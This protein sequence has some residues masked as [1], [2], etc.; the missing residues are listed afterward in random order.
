VRDVVLTHGHID[1]I[2]IAERA[3]KELGATV[4]VHPEDRPLLEHPLKIAESERSPVRYLRHGATRALFAQG[5]VKGAPLGKRV[6]EVRTF[7]DGET[8]AGV[9]GSPRVVFCPGHTRGH[10]AFHLAD[11]DVL[12]SGDAIVTRNPYTGETGPRIVSAAATYD[13]KLNLQSLDALAATGAGTVLT[14]HGDPWND[15]VQKAVE[16]ARAAGAS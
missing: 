10:C 14:G 12:F 2:G 15:G 9:A 6:Q 1:H 16:L 7:A 13:T 8:L 4:H 11:R 5:L 3:R